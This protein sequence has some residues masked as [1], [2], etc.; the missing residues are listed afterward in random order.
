VGLCLSRF[1]VTTVGGLICCEGVQLKSKK[2][3]PQMIIQFDNLPLLTVAGKNIIFLNDIFP[4]IHFTFW[5]IL[6]NVPI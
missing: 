2:I 4:K 5:P 3:R 1:V 6:G